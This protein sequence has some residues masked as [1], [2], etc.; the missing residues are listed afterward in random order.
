MSASQDRQIVSPLMRIL[1]LWR[2]QAPMLAVGALIALGALAAGIALMAAAGHFV[3]AAALGG[4]LVVPITLQVTG[5]AR[6]VLRYLER[7]V[8]HDATFR[9][10]AALRVWFFRGLSGSAAGGLGFRRAGDVLSRLVGDIEAL[11]GLYLRILVPALGAALLVP[12]LAIVIGRESV[13]AAV[14]VLALLFLVAFLLPWRAAVAAREAAGEEADTAGALRVSVLDALGGLREVKVFGAEGRM[15]ASV[16]AQESRLFAAA[17]ALASRGAA[18]QAAAFLA[19]QAALLAVLLIHGASPTAVVIAA[20]VTVAAFEAVGAMPRAGV[21]AG[22]AGAAATRV[23]DAATAP[24]PVAEPVQ[25]APM[26][27]SS[28][29]SFDSLRFRWSGDRPLV[30]DGL[31]LQLPAGARVAV[32]G[33]SGAGKSTL[34]VLALKLASPEAG[35]IRLGGTDI[36]TLRAEDVRARVAYL[37]QATHLFADTVRNNLLIA[38]PE[39]DEAM[40]WAALD[41]AQIGD[42]VRGLDDGLDAWVGE[43]GSQFSG[44]QGRRLVLARTLLST[45][46]ILIL[47]EPCTGLDLDT[48]RAFMATLNDNLGDRSLLLITHRLTGV[49]RLDRIWRLQSGKLNPATR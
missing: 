37:T 46:P 35:E 40:L 26:P 22:R 7:L 12:V 45:A 42:M 29:L 13:I 5:V 16:Q 32:L 43:Q 11:D 6:V 19:A 39:A 21:I 28:S 24:P 48:E 10:L 49:E 2:P 38:R 30:F 9:A 18:M 20:F 8:T 33:P 31:S 3:A 4:S 36:A 1:G 15:L 25:P 27:P 17:R 44:G 41:A 34:A 47:D 14:I 23:W